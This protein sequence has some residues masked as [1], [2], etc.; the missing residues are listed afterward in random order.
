MTDVST[1][2]PENIPYIELR[3]EGREISFRRDCFGTLKIYRQVNKGEQELL[4]KQARTP[5]IDTEK[6]PSGT[7]LTYTIELEQ[8]NDVQ[9]YTLKANV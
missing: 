4:I 5:Y 3:E 1:D 8:D 9:K 7:S 6:F 2:H